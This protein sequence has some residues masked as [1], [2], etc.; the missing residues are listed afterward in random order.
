M[1]QE[2]VL[3]EV[4]DSVV[5]SWMNI[6]GLHGFIE[7]FLLSRQIDDLL[8]HYRVECSLEVNEKTG[9]GASS[10]RLGSNPHTDSVCGQIGAFTFSPTALGV[11]QYKIDDTSNL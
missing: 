8:P 4:G 1:S 5:E 2:G 10:S 9:T 11:A 6:H 7:I 3:P